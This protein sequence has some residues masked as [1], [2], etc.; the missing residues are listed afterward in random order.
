MGNV[1]NRLLNDLC[2]IVLAI[3]RFGAPGCLTYSKQD[4]K[5]D[6]DVEDSVR[7]SL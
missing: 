1:T 6:Y 3:N 7:E 5:V 2:C 4:E